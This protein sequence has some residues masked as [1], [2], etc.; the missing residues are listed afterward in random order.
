M[1]FRPGNSVLEFYLFAAQR[2]LRRHNGPMVPQLIGPKFLTVLHNIVDFPVLETAAMLS[3]V[4]IG[5]LLGHRTGALRRFREAIEVTPAAVNLSGSMVLKGELTD[6]DMV[7]VI[8]LLR[9]EPEL[10]G[11]E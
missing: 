8:K 6:A 7:A 4:V 3:P 9:R 10:L 2:L 5:D 11:A 1:C